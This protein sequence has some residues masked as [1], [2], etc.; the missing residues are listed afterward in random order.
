MKWKFG[1]LTFAFFSVVCLVFFL[2]IFIFPVSNTYAL[3]DLIYTFDS[4]NTSSY[5]L[6]RNNYSGVVP[7]SNYNYVRVRHNI[8]VTS[9]STSTRDRGLGSMNIGQNGVMVSLSYAQFPFYDSL[10]DIGDISSISFQ[11]YPYNYSSV[12]DWYIEF[13]LS[14]NNPYSSGITPSGSLSITENGIY[15]VTEYAEAV[16]NVPVSSGGGGSG[17]YHDDLVNIYNAIM[18]C[19][20][21]I[22]V[23]YFFYCIYRMIIKS[24]GGR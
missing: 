11:P 17:D 14:E 20:A 3:E 1:H 18:T 23:L 10:F 24:T 5:V 13:T 7:C 12:S 16:V 8:P 22:L 6:C 9:L 4:S 2:S 15:D 21:V 19:G